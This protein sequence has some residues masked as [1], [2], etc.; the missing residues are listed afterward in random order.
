MNCKYCFN[1]KLVPDKQYYYHCNDCNKYVGFYHHKGYPTEEYLELDNHTV[2]LNHLFEF[3]NVLNTI[4]D[5]Q[6]HFKFIF[7]YEFINEAYVTNL[8]KEES[9][10]IAS[11]FIAT[12]SSSNRPDIAED[13]SEPISDS[14]TTT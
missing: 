3:T 6:Y 11:K 13:V 9:Y 7:P 4:N 1:T 10:D 12:S 14:T 2:Y 8:I 5:I